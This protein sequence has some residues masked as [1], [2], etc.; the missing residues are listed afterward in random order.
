VGAANH[1]QI[2]IVPLTDPMQATTSAEPST[3]Q[4]PRNT[5]EEITENGATMEPNETTLEAT[6]NTAKQNIGADP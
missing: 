2:Y 3:T 1:D 4:H 6:K 5:T